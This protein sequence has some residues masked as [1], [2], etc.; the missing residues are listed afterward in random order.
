LTINELVQ[1]LDISRNSVHQQVVKLEAAGVVEKREVRMT[2]SAGKPAH[3][4]RTVAGKED[5]HSQAYKPVLDS[6]IET[7]SIDLPSKSRLRLLQRAGHTLARASGLQPTKNTHSDLVRSVE[8]VNSLGAIAEVVRKG[9]KSHIT[10]YSCPVATLVHKEPLTCR[11]VAAFFEE[12]S[13][14]RV[15][16]KCRKDDTVVCGFV[17]DHTQAAMSQSD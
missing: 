6:L 5:S 10:C 16:V 7:I 8:A 17:V 11:M 14:K 2:Q 12:A 9:S 15:T 4:Y 3:Q 1:R 13:G